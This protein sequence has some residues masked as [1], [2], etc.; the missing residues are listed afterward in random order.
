MRSLIL[1]FLLVIQASWLA[2]QDYESWKDIFEESYA[3]EKKGEY[4]Q[5]LKIL[6]DIY[7]DDSYDIN[8]R[9][10]WLYYLIG[11]FPNSKKY[12]K[13]AMTILP[14]SLEAKFGYVLP[15]AGLG[16]W[17]E[18][19]A[20]YET[21]LSIDPKNTLVNYRMGAIYYEQKDYQKAYNYLEEVINLYPNDYPS[22]LLFAWTNLQMGKLKEAKILFHK[23]LLIK[24]DCESAA[25]GLSIIQ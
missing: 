14:Y 2:A 12:Y 20:V 8:I 15:L 22:N 9:H 5:S 21:M 23:V 10:G 4:Q 13:K 6:K 3:L 25:E 17:H 16:E 7:R 1:I 24:P 19:V 11:D 18:V